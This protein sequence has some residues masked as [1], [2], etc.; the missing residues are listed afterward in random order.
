MRLCDIQQ[1][2]L[3]L[4][5]LSGGCL[6]PSPSTRSLQCHH[7]RAIVNCSA[8][9]THISVG[10][11][12][13]LRPW[14]FQWW[15]AGRLGWWEG[16]RG[17]ILW[18]GVGWGHVTCQY[19]QTLQPVGNFLPPHLGAEAYFLFCGY[20]VLYL[21]PAAVNISIHSSTFTGFG[22]WKR[23][24]LILI[25]KTAGRNMKEILEGRALA[26]LKWTIYHRWI[27]WRTIYKKW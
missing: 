2:L 6:W 4:L 16:R 23:G 26:R 3:I 24:Q 13:L 25:E 22:Q 12:I 10:P 17:Y 11:T 20:A 27:E 8:W 7:W 5:L 21:R 1:L 18:A 15:A 9:S 14:T 19:L